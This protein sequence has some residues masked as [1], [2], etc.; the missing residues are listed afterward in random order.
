MLVQGV[1]RTL[2]RTMQQTTLKHTTAR[3]RLQADH[4]TQLYTPSQ[5]Q[6]RQDIQ[7][8]YWLKTRTVYS[9]T[10]HAWDQLK[11]CIHPPK[12]LQAPNLMTSS[13]K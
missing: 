6:Q 10:R 13:E 8:T 9:H 1:P 2:S 11:R 12:P 4:N 7:S 5:Q 3:S